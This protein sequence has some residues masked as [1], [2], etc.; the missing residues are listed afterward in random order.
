MEVLTNLFGIIILWCIRVSHHHVVH[1]KLLYMIYQ[2][3]L[4]GTMEKGEKNLRL[5][6]IFRLHPCFQSSASGTYGMSLYDRHCVWCW[7]CRDKEDRS[8]DLQEPVNS[9][10][11][12]MYLIS[13][14]PLKVILITPILSIPS[15]KLHHHSDGGLVCAL[16]LGWHY[17]LTVMVRW[18]FLPWRAC[19]RDCEDKNIVFFLSK[20]LCP[21]QGVVFGRSS[22]NDESQSLCQSQPSSF[23]VM[24]CHSVGAEEY[25][26][27]LRRNCL[28][29][30]T[31]KPGQG[32]RLCL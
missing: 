6:I 9:R 26:P 13:L 25:Q 8:T 31:L 17:T 32:P 4:S 7:G 29:K 22:S 21:D 20:S 5:G 3:Y 15:W 2:K 24:S 14:Y 1:L 19:S 23:S 18:V 11:G 30:E 12:V 10:M 16:Y 28:A 27:D